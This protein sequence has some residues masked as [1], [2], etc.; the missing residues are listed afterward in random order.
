MKKRYI[1]IIYI[2]EVYIY[3]RYIYLC[4][5]ERLAIIQDEDPT[6]LIN[7]WS[8]IISWCPHRHK[9]LLKIHEKIFLEFFRKWIISSYCFYTTMELWHH[10]PSLVNVS[11]NFNFSVVLSVLKIGESHETLSKQNANIISSGFI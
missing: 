7:E 8:S 3:K 9:H 11:C 1:Y 5:A 10:Q 2:Y 4:I 6:S